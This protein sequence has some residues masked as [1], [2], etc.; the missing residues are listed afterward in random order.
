MIILRCGCKIKDDGKFLVG[1]HCK[2]SGCRECNAGDSS[3]WK[4]IYTS[5]GSETYEK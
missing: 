4:H 3:I 2:K 1:E 5:S